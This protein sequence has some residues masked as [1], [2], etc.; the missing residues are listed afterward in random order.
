MCDVAAHCG[1][2][3]EVGA[4]IGGRGEPEGDAGS[5]P[6]L[7]L[8][9]HSGFAGWRGFTA[10]GIHPDRFSACNGSKPV[11]CT[12]TGKCTTNSKRAKPF[13]KRL[14]CSARRP[15]SVRECRTVMYRADRAASRAADRPRL[16]QE[17]TLTI[18]RKV[19]ANVVANPT[20]PKFRKLNKQVPF[21]PSGAQRPCP[22]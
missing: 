7:G 6:G 12:S 2:W 22:S 3:R 20:E 11:T 9:T 21:A 1:D 13:R 5:G 17:E 4:L 15:R 14:A 10:D 16:P 19:T 8:A 18:L